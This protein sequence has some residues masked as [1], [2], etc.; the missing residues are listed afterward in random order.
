MT[1]LPSAVYSSFFLVSNCCVLSFA[2]VSRRV[3]MSSSRFLIAT[4]LSW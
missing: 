3:A 2:M 4:S 1:S